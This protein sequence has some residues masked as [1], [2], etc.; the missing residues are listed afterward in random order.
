MLIVWL[1]YYPATDDEE[2][3]TPITRNIS[4]VINDG[5]DPI[6]GASVKIGTDTKTT[7][8]SGACSFNDI[9]EGTVAVEISKEGYTT[10]NEN[11]T[12]DETHTTFTIS[13]TAV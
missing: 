9:E 5:T 2:E 11:I 4:F 8:S 7:D 3:I 6:N 13:L 10:K 1:W 12:V